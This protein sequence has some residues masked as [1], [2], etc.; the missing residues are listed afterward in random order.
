[1]VHAFEWTYVSTIADEG[2]YGE[3]GIEEFEKRARKSGTYVGRQQCI[4]LNRVKAEKMV[5]GRAIAFTFTS[6][7]QKTRISFT[8]R[9]CLARK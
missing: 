5:W 1:L 8:F 9:R 3:K 6:L 2:N 4:E 7:I